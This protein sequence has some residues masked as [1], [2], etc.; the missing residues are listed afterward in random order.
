MRKIVY[1]CDRCKKEVS[2]DIYTITITG[3]TIN[4]ILTST[5]VMLS[6]M[7]NK[8]VNLCTKCK[9]EIEEFIKNNEIKQEDQETYDD[10]MKRMKNMGIDNKQEAIIYLSKEIKYYRGKIEKI[11]CDKQ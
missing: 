2:S 3:Q 10:T 5:K 4:G 11:E 7:G 9:T 6:N 1:I 8:P